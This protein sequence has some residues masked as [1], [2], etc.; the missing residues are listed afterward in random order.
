MSYFKTQID[1]D[2]KEYAL[3]YPSEPNMQKPEWAFNYWVL[4]KFFNEDEELIVDKII[5]YKDRGIDAYEWYEDTKELFLLQNKFYTTTKL[6]KEYVDNN[7]FTS[8]PA[9]S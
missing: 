9:M 3:R 6:T 4:D 8:V 1:E 5:D 2:I 7:Y